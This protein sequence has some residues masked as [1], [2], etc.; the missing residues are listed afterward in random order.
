MGKA[1]IRPAEPEDADIVAEHIYLAGKS[2]AKISLYELLFPGG[3]Q[4]TLDYLKRLILADTRSFFHYSHCLVYQDGEEVVASA[5]CYNEAES[6]SEKVIEACVEVGFGPEDLVAAYQRAASFYRVVPAHPED[7]WVLEHGAIS[8][9]YRG[10][11]IIGYL[12][13]AL[14][15]RGRERGYKKT[16]FGMFMG[17]DSALMAYKKKGFV[18]ADEKTDPE[19]EDLFGCPGMVRMIRGL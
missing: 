4:V 14:M 5:C 2:N 15:E 13:D 19:F 11:G 6:G 7:V 3:K 8:E 1:I 17:H 12:I 10:Q 9:E 18:L 16:E